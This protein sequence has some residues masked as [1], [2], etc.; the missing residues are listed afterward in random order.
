M[1]IS[2]PPVIAHISEHAVPRADSRTG[3]DVGPAAF[4][5]GLPFHVVMTPEE[6]TRR[7]AQPKNEVCM[8]S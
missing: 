2:E 3:R 1:P 8:P 7:F 6:A 5:D 4:P